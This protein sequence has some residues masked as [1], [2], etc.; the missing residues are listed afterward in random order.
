MPEVTLHEGADEEFKAAAVFYESRRPVLGELFVQRVVE[1]FE[2]ILAHPL[3]GQILFDEFRR[4]L[5]RQFPYSIVYRIEGD[6]IFVLAIAH[7]S[8]NPGYWKTRI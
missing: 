3:S 4:H 7:W 2:S 1:G 5:I 6:H 8:R